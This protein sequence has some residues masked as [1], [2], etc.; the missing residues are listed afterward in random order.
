MKKIF[1]FLLISFSLSSLAQKT[2]WQPEQVMKM[3]NIS[4][5]EVSP[6]GSK[7]VY[8]VREAVMTDDRSEYVN[9]IY[10]ANT[11]GSNAVQLTRNDKNNSSPKW[12]PEGKW[13]AFTS[14]RDGKNNLYRIAVEGGEAEKLTDVKTG[15]NSFDWSHDGSMIAFVQTDAPSDV[16]EKNK[17]GKNDWYFMDEEYKQARLSVLWINQNDTG[18]KRKVQNIT[19]E[20]RNIFGFDWSPNDEWIAYSHGVSAR[21]NDQ[22]YSDIS[23][24]NI[25]T[26]ERKDIAA[27]GAGETNPV[28]SP[29]GKMVAF[30]SSEDPV[31]WGGKEIIKIYNL[32]SGKATS[33]PTVP[34]DEGG[35]LGWSADGKYV[36]VLSANRTLQSIYRLSVVG[37]EVVEWNKGSKDFITN[38]SL[39][40]TGTHFGF[41]LQSPT[42]PADLYVSSVASFNPIRISNINPDIAKHPVPKTEVITWKSADGKEIEGLLTYPLN[43]EAGKKYPFILNVHG[44]PAGVFLQTFVAGNGGAYP[45]AAFAERGFFVLRPNPRGSSGYG[46]DFRLAN[47]RD[48]GGEDYKD[49]M[50]GVDHVIKM[51]MIDPQ[52]MGVMGWSYGGFMS[53]WI[54]GHTDRFK[55]ASI[56]APAT[57]LIVQNLSDDIGG[58]V[59]SY[60]K[61]HPWEDWEIYNERS[62]LRYVQ[63]VKTPVLL[64]HGESDIR[65]PFSEGVM[66]YNALKRRGVPV[67]FLVLPRQPHGP[68]EPKMIQKVMQTNLDWFSNYLKGEKRTL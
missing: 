63:N 51:G 56:G 7:V 37:N 46:V 11:D 38:V 39:N 3:K 1:F 32:G 4:A 20:N 44:G 28:F 9:Q 15:I 29:D 16:D 24:I 52:R 49:L 25:K 54:I 65:V 14:N 8:T 12:S 66:L 57:D 27:T 35:L 21:V 23:L 31:V 67:R 61:K 50:T 17:K 48:W 43:Y 5:V 19:K 47:Q 26:G 10:I 53:T 41:T 62:P 2:Y 36:Y 45:I 33:L 34:N 64:Q 55:A 6:D 40:R 58:F 22:V 68:T 60:M 18:G 13:I 59:P 42:K 30:Q